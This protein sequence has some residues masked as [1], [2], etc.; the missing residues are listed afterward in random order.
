MKLSE[1][2]LSTSTLGL[3]P[4]MLTTV[5]DLVWDRG[6]TAA[7]TIAIVEFHIVADVLFRDSVGALPRQTLWKCHLFEHVTSRAG[8]LERESLLFLQKKH[9]CSWRPEATRV[10][11]SVESSE[12]T[13]AGGAATLMTQTS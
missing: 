9:F 7:E 2:P 3:N 8:H 10:V 13:S 12:G 4:L 1:L 5:V 11:G 6:T